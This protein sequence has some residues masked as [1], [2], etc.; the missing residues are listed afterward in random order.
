M[1]FGHEM[2]Q[3]EPEIHDTYAIQ[4]YFRNESDDSYFEQVQDKYVNTLNEVNVF[5]RSK[6]AP[7]S[8]GSSFRLPPAPQPQVFDGNSE[9]YPMWRAAF[10]TLIDQLEVWLAQQHYSLYTFFCRDR[11]CLRYDAL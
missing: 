2:G 6:Q 5:L 8:E 10:S 9:H 4:Y 11:S 1:E 7:A 3:E